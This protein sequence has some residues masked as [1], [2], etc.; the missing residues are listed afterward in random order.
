MSLGYC[1]YIVLWPRKGSLMKTQ[2]RI[3]DNRLYYT[4]KVELHTKGKKSRTVQI[5]PVLICGIWWPPHPT[6]MCGTRS[7]YGGSERRAVANTRP[8]FPK[9]PSAPSA[10]PWLGV[11][12]VPGDE[13]NPPKEVKA[14]EEGPLRPKEISRYRVTLGQIRAAD[15]TAGRSA[16]RQL[17]RF[18]SRLICGIWCTPHLTGMYGTRPF[19]GWDRAQGRSPRAPGVCQKCL[20]PRRHSPF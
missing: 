9:M 2:T 1:E 8:A 16:T 3:L 13:P 4:R 7:F 18:R 5:T 11:P 6:G 14:W 10:F 12:Q 19:F 17:E 15:N 20:R